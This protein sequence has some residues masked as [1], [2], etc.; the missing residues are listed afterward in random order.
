MKKGI[1]PLVLLALVAAFVV[2]AQEDPVKTL[3]RAKAGY[4]HR[5]LDAVVQED[6]DTMEE[7][8]FRLKAVA[9]T[10]DWNV[11][12]T[13]E[14]AKESDSF[15]RATEKLEAAARERNGDAAALA[16]MDVTLKC[17]HCHRYLKTYR[18]ARD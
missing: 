3:M 9:G 14:Y 13:P 12:E 2:S 10:A 18:S 4:A 17:V 16:Y 8:A 11:I 7:Q 15:V 1:F 5:L 6:F